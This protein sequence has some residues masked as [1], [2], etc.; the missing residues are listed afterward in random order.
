MRTVL[1]IKGITGKLEVKDFVKMQST[2][3][4]LITDQLGKTYFVDVNLLQ[5][6]TY[7][8]TER[9]C[10]DILT[11]LNMLACDLESFVA[12]LTDLMDCQEAVSTEYIIRGKCEGLELAAHKI[13]ELM[14][15][16]IFNKEGE[17]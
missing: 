12:R 5:I 15:H 4:V 1:T 8:D 3:L 6:E 17:E 10:G 16:Y 11:E 9:S 14:K 2:T 7:P 13:R